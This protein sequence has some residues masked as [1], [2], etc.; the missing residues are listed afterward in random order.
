MR[1][2]AIA[3]QPAGRRQFEDAGKTAVVGEENEAFRVEIE[4]ADRDQAR[5]FF[6]QHFENCPSPLRVA[7]SRQQAARLVEQEQACALAFDERRAIDPD[8]VALRHIDGGARQDLP[9]TRAAAGRNPALR[10]AAR[11]EAGPRDRLCDALARMRL[12]GGRARLVASPIPVSRRS[13]DHPR[14]FT[15][16]DRPGNGEGSFRLAGGA[17]AK[18]R[19][20]SLDH[21]P[22]PAKEPVEDNRAL[23]VSGGASLTSP[24]VRKF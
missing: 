16:N 1:P 15:T 5:Q 19:R 2:H 22:F 11:A 10:I 9:I 20:R 14:P 12:L 21:L 23:T 6:W 8:L 4:S 7:G 18:A 17:L 13:I 3:T 24:F